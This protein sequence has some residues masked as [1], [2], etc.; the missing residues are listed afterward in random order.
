MA[1]KIKLL[2][3]KCTSLKSQITN[4]TNLV[5]QDKLDNITLKLR[6]IRLTNLYNDFEEQTDELAILS[7]SD[8][9]QE[10]FTRIQ[11]FMLSRVESKIS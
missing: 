10:E 5:D 7:P 1:D 2:I 6:M 8:E 4:L 3:Q 9:H 11:D